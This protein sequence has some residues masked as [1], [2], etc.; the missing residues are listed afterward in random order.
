MRYQ[1]LSLVVLLALHVPA[2]AQDYYT[3]QQRTSIG[4]YVRLLQNTFLQ[5]QNTLNTLNAQRTFLLGQRANLQTAIASAYN[6]QKKAVL[7]KQLQAN[8]VQIVAVNKALNGPW[9]TFDSRVPIYDRNATLAAQIDNVQYL[10]SDTQ[11]AAL[12]ADA[13][14]NPGLMFV[15]AKVLFNGTRVPHTYKTP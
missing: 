5:L 14:A 9:T 13:E 7:Q 8:H 15:V 2:Q 11:A 6:P 1:Y 12:E 3:L 4:L 10:L